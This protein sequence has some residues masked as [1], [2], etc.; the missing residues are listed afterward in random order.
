[1]DNSVEATTQISTAGYAVEMSLDERFATMRSIGLGSIDEEEELRVLPEKKV[2]PI[3]YVWC[4]P[5]PSVHIAQG[6][7]MVLNVNKMVKAGCRVKILM[8]DWFAHIHNRFSG[9][10]NDIQ[11]IGCYMIEVWK[12]ASLELNGVEFVW[13]S[14]EINRRP[15]EYWTLVMDVAINNTVGRMIRCWDKT[16]E[17]ALGVYGMPADPYDRPD[18]VAK[19]IFEPCMQCA[20]VLLPKAD[21]WL[22]SMD[23]DEDLEEVRELTREYC[24]DMKGEN[25]P[26]IL[27][28]NKLPDLIE[29]DEFGNIGDPAW[30][31][32]MEDGEQILSVKV[33][34]AFCPVKVAQG[35]PCLEYI[36]HVVFSWFGHC[37][38]PG[39]EEKSCGSRT[40]HKMEEFIIDYESGAPHSAEVKRALEEALK[41]IMKTVG[42]HFAGNSKAKHLAKA[43]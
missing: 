13:L 18:V 40:F 42:A 20:A 25:Q 21:I 3:C 28:H 39:K 16:F 29:D 14:D 2:A 1:M 36:R 37:E 34:K 7:M 24:K 15:H 23:H 9:D 11:T 32:F 38:V 35:N 27:S 12:T 43:M 6:I 4:D 5:S 31:I 17:Y 10:M 30:A 19:M 22:L 33:R 8:A 26:I 41:K